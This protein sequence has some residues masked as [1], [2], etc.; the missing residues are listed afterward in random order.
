MPQSNLQILASVATIFAPILALLVY[1]RRRYSTR[2]LIANAL[3][4]EIDQNKK[5]LNGMRPHLE[6]ANIMARK[7][8]PFAS[9]T[10]RIGNIQYNSGD[11]PPPGG[12]SSTV[13][14]STASDI[15]R[16]DEDIADELVEY[17]HDLRFV[18][19]LIEVIHSGETLPPAAYTILE[20]RM[21]KLDNN[22]D[23]LSKKLRVEKKLF[24]QLSRHFPRLNQNLISTK[25]FLLRVVLSI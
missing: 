15:S 17:Y 13:Y 12:I 10:Q 18:E 11:I 9:I 4:A 22:S 16:F 20:S 2:K 23:K 21:D 24:P 3:E 14:E 7:P 5:W 1:W 19:S 8:S 25:R 6:A